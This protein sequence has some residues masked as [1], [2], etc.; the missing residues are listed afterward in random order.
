ML[1]YLDLACHG[2]LSM[3]L[4]INDR[5]ECAKGLAVNGDT[6]HRASGSNTEPLK[7]ERI[8]FRTRQSSSLGTVP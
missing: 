5:S 1:L 6:K 8:A 4:G 2:E 3:A 7:M